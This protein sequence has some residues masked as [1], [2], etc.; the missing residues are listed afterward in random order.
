METSKVRGERRDPRW[1]RNRCR[2]HR[3]FGKRS[4]AGQDPEPSLA[5]T[6]AAGATSLGRPEPELP[7]SGTGSPEVHEDGRDTAALA[8]PQR[9]QSLWKLR[10]P[11][12]GQRYARRAR[13]LSTVC[14]LRVSS[15]CSWMSGVF[16]R[17]ISPITGVI[18]GLPSG[19]NGTGAPPQGVLRKCEL[20]NT[21][22]P[23]AGSKKGGRSRPPPISP[24][25]R[26]RSGI[27]PQPQAGKGDRGIRLCNV[28]SPH[29]VSD[30]RCL[31][32]TPGS[33]T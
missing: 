21:P 9:K 13:S 26:R 3:S 29:D 25:G 24:C 18:P 8:S 4:S 1:Q 15:R 14:F 10:Y 22:A 30:P 12:S 7:A 17:P 23:A 11:Q 16:M 27:W 32:Y 2:T 19:I 31:T 20:R 5:E 28:E 6:S 33:A